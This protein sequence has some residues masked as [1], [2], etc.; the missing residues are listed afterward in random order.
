MEMNLNMGVFNALEDNE[1]MEIDGG[2]DWNG[3]GG[4]LS[5]AAGAYIGSSDAKGA[6]AGSFIGGAAGTVVGGLVG[7]VAGYVIYSWWD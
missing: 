6:K 4:V 5:S 3:V 7:G 1:M 2:I